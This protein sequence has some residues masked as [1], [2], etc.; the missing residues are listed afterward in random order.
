MTPLLVKAIIVA[1]LVVGGSTAGYEA[2]TYYSASQVPSVDSFI[3]QNA[4]AVVQYNN[5]SQSIIAFQ[6]N[7]SAA[8]IENVAISSFF[9]SLNNT[10]ENVTH[11]LV[12]GVNI[13]SAGTF[14]GYQIF[15]VELNSSDL[16]GQGFG[17]LSN[18]IPPYF[19]NNTTGGFNLSGGFNFT[20]GFNITGGFGGLGDIFNSSALYASPITASA[21]LVGGS[22]AVYA[23]IAASHSGKYFNAKRY[24]NQSAN[25]SGYIDLSSLNIS[26]VS[27]VS[28]NLTMNS[29][30]FD[31]Q[32]Y[33]TFTSTTYKDQAYLLLNQTAP[34]LS[35]L[36][37]KDL[38]GLSL[39]VMFSGSLDSLN[40]L[41][42]PA[43]YSVS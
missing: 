25:I 11:G 2:V 29:T 42:L 39:E 30:Y 8:I 43:G 37:V 22:P 34:Y 3:P 26:N 23:S 21:T 14:D 35:G 40:N 38:G 20:G 28:F 12:S 13:T 31:V 32:A 36:K 24:L 18:H 10:T 1:I 27:T 4:S 6:A 41:T 17:N 5:Q 9:S 7:N 19:G 16:L 15:K 33:L